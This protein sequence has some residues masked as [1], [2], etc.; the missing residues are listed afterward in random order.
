RVVFVSRVSGVPSSTVLASM[1]M[2][3]LFDP[4]GFVILLVAGVLVFELPPQFE[5]WKIPAEL[6][7]VV[8]VVLLVFF[9]YATRRMKPDHV[10]ARRG[11]ARPARGKGVPVFVCLR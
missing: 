11:E 5:R 6:L 10:P 8:I 3:K 1:A 2:E 4:I 7:L 9:V